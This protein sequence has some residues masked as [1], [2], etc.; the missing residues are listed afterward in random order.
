[1]GEVSLLL[2]SHLVTKSRSGSLSAS[3]FPGSLGSPE[4]LEE[5]FSVYFVTAG[6]LA[7]TSEPHCGANGGP[8]SFVT[9]HIFIYTD[10]NSGE[11]SGR[12]TEQFHISLII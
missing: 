11:G 8:V 6:L 7:V 4:V 10:T 1:M 12:Q 2:L 3:T 9:T 5:V